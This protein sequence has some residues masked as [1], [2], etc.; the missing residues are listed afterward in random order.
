MADIILKNVAFPKD[1]DVLIVDI[2]SDQKAFC[3]SWSA[4]WVDAIPAA[5]VAPVRHGVWVPTPCPG[6]ENGYLVVCSKCKAEIYVSNDFNPSN[7]CPN[8]GTQMDGGV[9]DA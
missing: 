3:Y 8:C 2:Y 5:D 1:E 6:I 7:Y 9:D 4:T